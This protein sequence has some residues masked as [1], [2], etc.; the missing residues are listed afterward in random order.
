MQLRL[1]ILLVIISVTGA[2]GQAIKADSTKPIVIG[3]TVY[4]KSAIL[5][6]ERTL[7]IYLPAGYNENDTTKY[8]VVYLLDGSIDEDFINVTGQYYFNNFPWVNRTPNSI[9]VG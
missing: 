4:I 1:S 2:L 9:I 5:G 7:N 8:A 3:K 6:E